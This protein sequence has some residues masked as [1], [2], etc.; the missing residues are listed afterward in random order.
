MRNASRLMC[1]LA[2]TALVSGCATSIESRS[3][4]Q[5]EAHFLN[6]IV[7]RLP[8]RLIKVEA[9]WE[10]TGCVSQ[11]LPEG[12]VTAQSPSLTFKP[13]VS[14]TS[15]TIEGEQWVIDYTRLLR[16]W[17]IGSLDIEFWTSGTGDAERQTQLIKSINTTVDGREMAALEAG[18]GLV[19]S[20][21]QL[22]L[23][24]QGIVA[25]S[26]AG[27]AAQPEP[28][29]FAQCTSETVETIDA[30]REARATQKARLTKIG[31]LQVRLDRIKA[32]TPLSGPT[33]SDL[34]ALDSINGELEGL[35]RDSKSA[36]DALT[37]LLARVTITGSSEYR[38]FSNWQRSAGPPQTLASAL[39]ADAAGSSKLYGSAFQICRKLPGTSS[40]ECAF[41]GSDTRL[42]SFLQSNL[43]TFAP[44]SVRLMLSPL[45]TGQLIA[46]TPP[47]A[48][49]E[50]S[51]TCKLP[52]ERTS[53]P[54]CVPGIVTRAPIAAQLS[55]TAPNDDES[56]ASSVVTIPQLGAYQVL[57]YRA[58]SGESNVL[59]LQMSRDGIPSR[60][61]W[62]RKTAPGLNAI[63]AIGGLFDRAAPLVS[64]A[65]EAR[66]TRQQEA[67]EEAAGAAIAEI[68]REL[69]LVRAQ[70]ELAAARRAST[71][72]PS[73]LL[74]QRQEELALAK[75]ELDLATIQSQL[76]A[77]QASSGQQ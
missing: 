40:A 58:G 24:A 38:D 74:L 73:T 41:D 77:L 50:S 36:N 32:R 12:G 63:Q 22:A 61:R 62:E 14:V 29:Y 44:P 6:G 59:S 2:T 30:I 3:A 53:M 60:V 25:P 72:G 45:N 48:A 31:Q 1:L 64:A 52:K 8:E 34:N 7:Y 4:N 57:P 67:E 18:V 11:V 17:K 68:N 33:P 27:P 75:L 69:A 51:A 66:Q 19:A 5:S 26:G 39:L 10:L 71:G 20:A 15:E 23:A 28:R 65:E 54:D 49:G 37:A 70:N 76:A 9:S 43:Q 16:G 55:I 42:A 13:T 46:P 56:L 35:A 21:A 47:R